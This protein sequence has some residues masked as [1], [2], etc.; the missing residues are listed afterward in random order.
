[1]SDGSDKGSTAPMNARPRPATQVSASAV[2]ST[3]ESATE[4]GKLDATIRM[5]D[6][7]VPEADRHVLEEISGTLVVNEAAAHG[8]VPSE[9][10]RRQ[11]APS[12]KM[13]PAVDPQAFKAAGPDP[14]PEEAVT[15]A[16][17]FPIVDRAAQARGGTFQSGYPGNGP[18]QYG[19]PGYGGARR[20]MSSLML[21]LIIGAAVVLVLA[22]GLGAFAFLFLRA[23][24]HPP[25]ITI[26]TAT[27][28]ATVTATPTAPPAASTPPPHPVAAPPPF[29][30]VPPLATEPPRGA[31]RGGRGASKAE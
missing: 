3:K 18:A 28:T 31:H 9:P 20:G 5:D 7:P 10:M 11:G 19:A 15:I 22:L 8:G 25:E 27:A 24:A 16:P 4:P 14:R 2:P 12:T 26:A 13:S 29:V 1:M 30:P 17:A 23:R 6:S 21:G